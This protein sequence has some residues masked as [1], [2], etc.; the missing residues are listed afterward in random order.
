MLTTTALSTSITTAKSAKPPVIIAP[1]MTSHSHDCL[2]AVAAGKATHTF[3]A[4]KHQLGSHSTSGVPNLASADIRV[5]SRSLLQ[6]QAP[7]QLMH[8]SALPRVAAFQARHSAAALLCTAADATFGCCVVFSCEGSL[9]L[10][11]LKARVPSDMSAHVCAI[12]WNW[13]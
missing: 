13:K 6:H 10:L 11:N 3:H 2:V 12:G 5:A 1:C 9:S 4:V 8:W 7:L